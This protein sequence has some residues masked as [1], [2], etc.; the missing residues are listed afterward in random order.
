[1]TRF[2]VAMCCALVSFSAL[3]QFVRSPRAQ[4]PSLPDCPA[5]PA[6]CQINA[7]T[8]DF[9]RGQMTPA[10]PSINGT[11]TIS[12]TCTRAVR[13][14]L[15]VTVDYNLKAVPAEPA[16]QMR[17]TNLLF[18]TY[19][20]FV[21]PARTRYWGDGFTYGTFTFQGTVFL[22][23]RNRVGSLAHVVYGKVPGA[24]SPTPPGQWL[25]LVGL[26]LE[27]TAVCTG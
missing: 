9:G 17:D 13:D 2:A 8:F 12:V 23:D 11:N 26:Q 3:P 7:Q 25:G 22:D 20:M 18:L 6:E 10:S 4:G 16:R 24:Q 5:R 19:E 21:D 15:R 1:M 14:G 27:Y